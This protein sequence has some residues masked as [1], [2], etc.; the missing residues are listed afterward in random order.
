MP[1]VR[2]AFRANRLLYREGRWLPAD[3]PIIKGR[4]RFF[5]FDDEQPVEQATAAPGERRTTR[6]RPEVG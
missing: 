3:H 5:D 2:E 1:T 6:R 4:E